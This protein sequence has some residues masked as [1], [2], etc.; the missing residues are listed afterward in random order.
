M[1]LPTGLEFT[2]TTVRFADRVT[3]WE[4]SFGRAF[5]TDYGNPER[6]YEVL[7]SGV[8]AL[9]Y[10]TIRKWFVEGP[11]AAAAVDSVFSRN[12]V[13]APVG[14]ILYGVVVDA[15]GFMIEDVTVFVL[16]STQI[17]MLGGDPLTEAQLEAAVPP[18]TTVTDRRAEYAA[19]SIQGP[20]SR[21]LLQRLTDADISNE[22]LPYYSAL[23]DV[24]VAGAAASILRLG[25]TAELGYEVMVPVADA[26]RLWDAILAQTDLGI[27]MMGITAILVARTEAGMVMGGFEYDRT[28]TPFEC[29][30]GWTVDFDK[31]EFQG[32]QALLS[33][34]ETP[35][36][37]LVSLVVD[38]DAA[39]LDGA[40]VFHGDREVGRITMAVRSPVLD[41]KTLALALVDRDVAKP[42]AA[43][44]LADGATATRVAT[45]VYDPERTRAKS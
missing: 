45:P 26:D 38:A 32:R 22:A 43:V 12:V 15:D 9:E 25:F 19:A 34:K 33:K 5:A 2:P 11:D 14:R 42:G 29:G 8:V 44:T 21:E 39:G 27:E 28:M 7:R 6:E 16:S 13:D 37:R 36:L 17:V 1:A 18:G 31:P 10:S 35:K 20:L 4:D 40:S 30:L 41:G 24:T 3:D 23:T